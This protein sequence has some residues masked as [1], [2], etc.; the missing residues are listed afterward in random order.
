[1]KKPW[2]PYA[3]HILITIAKIHNIQKRGKII[4]DEILYDAA[5]RNLQ[6]LSEAT[7]RLTEEKTALCPDIPWKE[8]S[9]FRSFGKVAEQL[10]F[11]PNHKCASSDCLLTVRLHVPSQ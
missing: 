2:Q 1:M 9:G 6:T 10:V 11:P 5:L 3:Q 7:Q 8:I 4:D